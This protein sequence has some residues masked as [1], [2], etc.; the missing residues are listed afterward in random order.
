MSDVR[1]KMEDVSLGLR[2]DSGLSSNYPFSI[3][4]YQLKNFNY[5]KNFYQVRCSLS[6]RV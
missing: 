2:G 4:N 5:E 6:W 3:I 1:W